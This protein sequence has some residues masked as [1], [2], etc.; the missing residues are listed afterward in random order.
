MLPAYQDILVATDFTPNSDHA[1]KHA[2]MLARLH[3]AKIH[4]IHV[5]AQ[6][7]TS[8]RSYISAVMGQ[9]QLEE[10]EQSHEQ[11]AHA[12]LKKQLHDF[13]EKELAEFP[14]DLKRFAGAEVFT[15]NPVSCILTEAARLNADVIVMGTH[16]KG[17]LEHAF[18]G[19]VAEK[20]LQK[21]NRPIFVI[22]LPKK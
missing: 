12:T 16:S 6:V 3:Q 7:D 2:V 20:V 11:E 14:D 13:A 19:S 4:L 22:P 21:S 5:V 15:G 9:D 1:F 17:A 8:M 18:L 10:L